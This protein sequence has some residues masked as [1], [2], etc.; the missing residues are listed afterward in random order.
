[1]KLII[2]LAALLFGTL[3]GIA[4][5]SIILYLSKDLREKIS[6]KLLY[7]AGGAL[8][9]AAFLG[10]IPEI[11]EHSH[12]QH[13]LF[14]IPIGIF[15][16]FII[17]KIILWRTCNDDKC[18]RHSHATA[19]MITIGDAF[20]NAIDGIAIASS[21]TIS[22]EFGILTSIGVFIHEIPQEL[23]DFGILI[24]GGLSRKKALLLNFLSA[25]SA[26][27][28]GL[29]AFFIMKYLDKAIIYLM[30]LSAASF[31]YISLA[32][33]IPQMHQKTRFKDTIYQIVFVLLGFLTFAL[34]INH[35]H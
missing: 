8:I 28:F 4:I 11:Y 3:G 6:T 12:A 34:I 24:N 31:I 7:F 26:I 33:L 15:I 10:L 32:D 13:T 35:K 17:E 5:S 9:G 25:F 22:I 1:M 19:Y 27:I 21:F 16:F 18:E 14:L 2:F 23:A 29:A 20:H 30:A